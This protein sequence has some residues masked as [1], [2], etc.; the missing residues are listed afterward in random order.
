[1]ARPRRP[2]QLRYGTA[3]RRGRQL[4][5]FRRIHFAQAGR[6][7]HAG[8]DSDAADFRQSDLGRSGWQGDHSPGRVQEAGPFRSEKFTA[9]TFRFQDGEYRITLR[10][11]FGIRIQDDRKYRQNNFSIRFYPARSEGAIS[12][13]ELSLSITLEKLESTP[14]D[15]R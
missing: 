7:R 9:R 15:I 1:M 12:Q 3:L 13:S 2:L 11:D 6:H 14:V 10:G 8:A 5:L 4:S